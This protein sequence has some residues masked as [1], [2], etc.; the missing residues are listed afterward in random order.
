MICI[1][2]SWCHCQS[3]TPSSLAPVKSRMI[4]LPGASLPRLF[5]KKRPLNECSSSIVC[6][7]SKR[8]D[9]D[10]T[11]FREHSPDGTTPNSG[12]KH[13]IAAY[14]SFIDL[15]GMKGWVGLVGWPT[16]NRLP[17]YVVTHQLQVKHRTRKVRRPKTDVLSLCHTT[18]PPVPYPE[19]VWLRATETGL[20]CPM[21]PRG[22][23]RTLCYVFI[24]FCNTGCVW[25]WWI[26]NC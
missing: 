2:S 22:M 19:Y 6:I 23:E 11:V 13:P 24:F 9:M 5:W 10:H 12:G 26:L 20:H 3:A 17:T 25:H 8:S 15:E 14:Y 21:G 7:L 18:N 16:A 1:W 4:Y